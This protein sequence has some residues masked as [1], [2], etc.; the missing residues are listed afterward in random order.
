[1]ACSGV[2]DSSLIQNDVASALT[3]FNARR[4]EV[5]L[6][7]GVESREG[8]NVDVSMF[9]GLFRWPL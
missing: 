2:A 9:V 6:I 3:F 5:R 4:I 7:L 1:M 8:H